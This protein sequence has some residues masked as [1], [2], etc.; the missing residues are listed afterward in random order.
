MPADTY[1]VKVFVNGN[2]IPIYQYLR[3]DQAYI[4]VRDSATP[5]ITSLIPNFGLPGSFVTING[6][7]KVILLLLSTKIIIYIF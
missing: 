5:K 7:F 3:Q 6:D 2:L 1:L 4:V